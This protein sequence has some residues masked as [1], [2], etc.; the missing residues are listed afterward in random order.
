M[1]I[2][3]WLAAYLLLTTTAAA[4]TIQGTVT[5]AGSPVVGATVRLLELDRTDRTG[6]KGEFRFSDVP[7]GTYRV[8]VG[9]TG[10]LAATDTVRLTESTASLTFKLT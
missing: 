7:R 6:S 1:P 2:S 10:Y 9:V 4:Q 3:R 5:S 8:Y